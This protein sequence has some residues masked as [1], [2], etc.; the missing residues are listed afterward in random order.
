M[1]LVIMF[2]IGIV[3]IIVGM[4]TTIYTNKQSI[5]SLE[6]SL[7]WE[8]VAHTGTK[9]N[10]WKLSTDKDTLRKVVIKTPSLIK[11]MT[12]LKSDNVRVSE[13]SILLENG[14]N[15]VIEY[16]FEGLFAVLKTMDAE[17]GIEPVLKVPQVK[18]REVR[19]R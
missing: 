13:S 4:I 10:F 2:S 12:R 1:Y 16:T 11:L 5:K 6:A 15:T 3:L 19:K 9:E 8:Q 18:P 14:G 7:K 17:E